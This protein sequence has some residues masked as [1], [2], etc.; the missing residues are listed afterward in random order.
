MKFEKDEINTFQKQLSEYFDLSTFFIVV[1]LLA[2]G[3]TSIYSATY[4]AGM[5]DFF[6]KQLAFSIAGAVGMIIVMFI[7]ET[8]IQKLSYVAYGITLVLLVL[9]K[10]IGKE[11]SGTQGW[12]DLGSF[13]LQPSEL[14][15]LTTLL[16]VARYL[17]IQGTDIKTLRDL[18]I[19]VGLVLLPFGLIAWQPDFGTG[20]V[21][22]AMLA[23][24]L[25]WTGFDAFLLFLAVSLPA[26]F[27]ASLVNKI[28][29]YIALGL[30][31]IGAFFFRKKVYLTIGAIAFAAVIGFTSNYLI[32][33]FMPHQKD[34]IETFLNPGSDPRGKGYNAIQATMAV[35]AGGF[36]G[37][38]F[39]QGL[40]TQLRYIPEQRT[41]FIFCVLSEEFGFIGGSAVILLI[42]GLI[43]RS[44]KIAI[45]SDSKFMSITCFGLAAIFFYHTLINIGMVIGLMPVMGI[46]LPFL[47]YGGSSHLIN[48][49]L[50]G[51]VLN[52][53]RS[54]RLRRIFR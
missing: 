37:K 1:L 23:G 52:A 38:G 7:P 53:Y 16:A 22:I 19:T 25:Y 30:F 32:D 8:W 50:V 20:T 24:V 9:V 45:E 46:P 41:D 2:A 13:S 26:I 11:I 28:Y 43:Y 21:L 17:S 54:Q 42:C 14:A 40:Q 35:G 36:W 6:Y 27:I 47:S 48:L 33:K 4:E 44:A 39:M 3:L 15:K 12:F 31:A 51:L 18:G 49:T 10:F 34:R 5:S 29:V